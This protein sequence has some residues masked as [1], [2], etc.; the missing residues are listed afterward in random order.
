MEVCGEHYQPDVT[1]EEAT[2]VMEN[3]S[4]HPIEW[5][6]PS[7]APLLHARNVEATLSIIPRSI[8]NEETVKY[9]P[10][11]SLVGLAAIFGCLLAAVFGLDLALGIPM[12]PM[13]G[14][15]DLL[16]IVEF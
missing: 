5:S 8:N 11:H 3:S 16:H 12:L 2:D 6:S 10:L 9:Y 4:S 7:S 1:N 13:M 15:S 14:A